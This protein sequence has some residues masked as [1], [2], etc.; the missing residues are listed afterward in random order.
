MSW[1]A[2]LEPFGRATGLGRGYSVPR[3]EDGGEPGGFLRWR[4][5]APL[6]GL[7]VASVLALAWLLLPPTG[8]DLSAQVAHAEFAGAHPWNP[9]DLQWFGGTSLLGYSVIVPPLMAVLGVRAVGA[10]ATVLAAWLFGILM[11][12]FRVPRPVAGTVAGALCLGANLLVGRLTFAVGVAAALLTLTALTTSH[13]VR[14]VLLVLGPVLTWA[15]SPLAVLFLALVGA[16]L[17]VRRHMLDGVL[18]SASSL[19]GLGAS[20]WVGQGGYMP[21]PG[22]GV[23]VGVA[24]CGLVAVSTRYRLVQVGALLAAV[25]IILAMAVHTQVG[26]NALRLPALFAAPLLV[27]TSRLRARVLVPLVALTVVLVPPLKTGDVTAIGD[28]TDEREYFTALTAELDRLPLT[29]RV[30]IPPTLHRWESVYV[31]DDV[32]LARGWM[33][34]LDAGYHPLFFEESIDSGSYRHW[35]RHNGVQY[36][37]VADAVPAAAGEAEL[38]LIASG[39]GYLHE[40][41]R[42]EHWVVY[43]VAHPTATV[44]GGR[45]LSQDAV[46][47]SFATRAPGAVLLRVRWSK[48]LTLAGSGGC[49]RR[50]G[51]WTEV[52]ATRAG[53]YRVGSAVEPGDRHRTCAMS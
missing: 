13:R 8:S 1:T 11:S 31:A 16:T 22:A 42:G 45:L 53:T 30:E 44:A 17:V 36:V 3:G 49:L 48:W 15:A 12:R 29:G 38:S 20:L 18:L 2:P 39:L 40:I 14:W 26:F 28:P 50:H 52:V 4:F 7:G 37:A 10:A 19:A 21:M 41:W 23:V 24:V 33:T 27:A 51:S 32:P 43:A 25:G 46:S 5:S 6:V 9:V 47:I 35:L 34:Q